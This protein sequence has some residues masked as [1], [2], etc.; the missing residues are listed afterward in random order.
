MLVMV[1]G[2][3]GAVGQALVPKLVAAGHQVVATA[4]RAP[5]DVPAGV[6]TR[7]VDLLDRSSVVT[8]VEQ[9]QP[10]AI[11]PSGHC[12][13]RA[14]QQPAALRSRV[15]DHQPAA[16]RRHSCLDRRHLRHGQ[17]AAAGGAKLLRMAVGVDR[18]S[19]ED[20]D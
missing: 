15:R 17:A 19:G 9:I 16:H 10:E 8:A 7:A 2:A 18:W 12:P 1:V 11:H 5:Q 4:R 20:R 6:T 3:S 13:E 14:R